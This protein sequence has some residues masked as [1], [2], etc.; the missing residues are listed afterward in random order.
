MV[1]QPKGQNALATA[2]RLLPIAKIA[3]QGI[4]SAVLLARLILALQGL[5]MEQFVRRA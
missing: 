2:A 5:G 1:L 4:I 3:M